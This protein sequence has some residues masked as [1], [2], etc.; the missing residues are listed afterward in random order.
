MQLNANKRS[1]KRSC[2]KGVEQRR[3]NKVNNKTKTS[4]LDIM[5]DRLRAYTWEESLFIRCY[6][7]FR[8]CYSVQ[9]L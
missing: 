7:Y 3:E 4:A 5:T 8:S 9:W 1:L 2:N 6:F